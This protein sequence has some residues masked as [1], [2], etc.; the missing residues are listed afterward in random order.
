MSFGKSVREE[1]VRRGWSQQELARKV[2]STQSTI[3][4]IERGESARSRLA[5]ALSAVL[6]IGIP[7]ETADGKTLTKIYVD[8]V[9]S[10]EYDKQSLEIF[11]THSDTIESFTVIRGGTLVES[12]LNILRGVKDAFGILISNYNM[13]PAYD[14]GDHAFVHPHLPLV[15]DCDVLIA[16]PDR[17]TPIAPDLT[18]FDATVARLTAWDTESWRVKYWNLDGRGIHE[19]T[20]L[21]SEWPRAWRIVGK[22]MRV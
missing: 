7:V 6:E 17:S 2:G 3:D 22:A 19:R 14:A 16:K 21:R 20:L 9:I 1:R 18:I 8:D 10:S 15:R 11:L 5:P 13:E 4:R 12:R